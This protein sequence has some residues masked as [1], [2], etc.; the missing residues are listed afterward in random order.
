MDDM[1]CFFAPNTKLGLNKGPG[2][3]GRSITLK[4]ECLPCVTDLA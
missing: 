4:T 3:I 2:E 1:G